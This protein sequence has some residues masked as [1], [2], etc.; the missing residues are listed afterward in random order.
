MTPTP[1]PFLT[2]ERAGIFRVTHIRNVPWILEHGLHCR[3]SDAQD[4]NFVEIGIHD[5]IERRSRQPVSVDPGGFLSDYVPFY[6]TP[7]SVMMLKIVSGHGVPRVPHGD[8]VVIATSLHRLVALGVAFLLTDRHASLDFAN[9]FGGLDG[10]SRIDW[11]TLRSSDFR[12]CDEDMERQDRYQAEALVHRHLPVDAI[13]L[14]ACYSE[15]QKVVLS[16]HLA[17][18]QLRIP[19][20]V[21]PDWFFGR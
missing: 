4:P 15:V 18:R 10:L 12:N 13:E 7:K 6:F 9:F 2:R 21:H 14:I 11:A 1:L 17:R 20:E 5:L 3:S 19:I 8:L 16:E